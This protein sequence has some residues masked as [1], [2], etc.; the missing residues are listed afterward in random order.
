MGQLYKLYPEAFNLDIWKKLMTTPLE[1]TYGKLKISLQAI[2]LAS[3][4]VLVGVQRQT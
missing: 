4:K 3:Q 1:T 2:W